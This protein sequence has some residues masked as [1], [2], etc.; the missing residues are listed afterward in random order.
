MIIPNYTNNVVALSFYVLFD[1]CENSMKKWTGQ[2]CRI[3]QKT[4]V[5]HNYANSL[6]E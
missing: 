4:I 6:G 1:V 5:L 2:D 3:M